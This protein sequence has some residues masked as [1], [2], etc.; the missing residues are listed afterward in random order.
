MVKM[1]EDNLKKI[2]YDLFNTDKG[3]VFAN[4]IKI[5]NNALVSFKRSFE[6]VLS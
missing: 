5:K 2:Q 4:H 1:K 6:Q 3:G